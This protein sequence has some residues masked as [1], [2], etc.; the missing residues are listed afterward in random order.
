MRSHAVPMIGFGRKALARASTKPRRRVRGIGQLRALW[1]VELDG[2][3]SAS[4]A[5]DSTVRW[6]PVSIP[7]R[8]FARQASVEEF[9]GSHC[10]ALPAA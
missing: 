3:C 8:P 6:G 4:A 5:V 7:N 10:I 2:R 9:L 1:V